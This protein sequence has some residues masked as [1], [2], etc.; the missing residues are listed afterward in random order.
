MA[1]I[2]ITGM[3]GFLGWHLR[4]YLNAIGTH[5]AV[6]VDRNALEVPQ[7]LQ[8]VVRLADV[9]VHFAGMNRGKDQDIERTNVKLTMQLIHIRPLSRTAITNRKK[10]ISR[11]S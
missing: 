1:T 10:V 4:A 11:L 9:I 3:N 8:D 6:G 7:L 2:A 5:S